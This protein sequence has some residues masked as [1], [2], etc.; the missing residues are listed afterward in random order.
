VDFTRAR[1]AAPDDPAIRRAVGEF[2]LQRGTWALAIPELQAAVALDS[3]DV[4]SRYSLAQ[5]LFYDQRYDEAL[6]AYQQ[7]RTQA[8]DYA[9]GLLGLGDLLYRAG[10][11]D[12]RR[13]EEARGPLQDYVGLEPADPKGW[14]LLGRTLYRLGERDSAL[15]AMDRAERLGDR[16]KEL[17]SAMA[18]AYA[19]R[20]E[21]D[22]ALAA[23]EKGEP[24]PREYP[25]LG[26]IYEVT[27][28]PQ[29][30]DSVYRLILERDSTST[31]A[32]FA[33]DQ[34]AKLRFR[35]REFRAADSL[36]Q[37]A[38]ALDPGKGEAWFYEGL[39]LKE[40]GREPEALEHLRRAATIDSTSADRFFWLG[41]LADA[42]RQT[43]EAERAFQRTVTLDSTGT[44]AA[45]AYRQLGYYRLLK[46]QWMVAIPLLDRAVALDPQ[47]AQAWLWLAQGSQNAGDRTRAVACYRRVLALD[48]A[49]AEAKKGLRTLGARP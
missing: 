24:D 34:R 14:S 41:V 36:F 38:L 40:L 25:L 3:T 28:H 11:A 6:Q 32:A 22:R 29:Q 46:R 47:D 10:A 31:V 17:Y 37:R 39:T 16:S 26:Q 33:F 21:W 2:Y 42:L 12:P 48:P 18:I 19:D 8:P 27:G 9:P 23:F 49:N 13:Y 30:A 7:L 15:A 20:R 35:D 1:E 45:K 44:L 4:E 5:A 43:G